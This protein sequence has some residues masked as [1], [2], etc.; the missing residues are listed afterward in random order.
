MTNSYEDKQEDLAE[1]NR[2]RSSQYSAASRRAVQ[3]IPMG[4]PILV[5]HHSEG[6]H[7]AALARS[8]SAMRKSI[9]HYE[10]K[11]QGV[12]QGGISSDDPEAVAKLRTELE[13]L[14]KAQ[15]VMKAANKVI[16]ANKTPEARIAA[17]VKV[18]LTEAQAAEIIKP[19]FAGRV[20]FAPYQL[21]NASANMRRIEERIKVLQRAR[22]ARAAKRKA[23]A[24]PTAKTPTRTA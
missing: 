11:A 10:R 12:G 24:T 3:A 13:Q 6:R 4:Q 16:R 9:E 21:S 19:D 17:L 20:G 18:G 22:D 8:D 2:E 15:G 23:A 5:D 7:R 14:Q 1:K